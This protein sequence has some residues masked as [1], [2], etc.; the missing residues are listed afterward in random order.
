MT[1]AVGAR[2]RDLR[3]RR[4]LTLEDV[5]A[6]TG[7]S[8]ST[9]SRLE[10][11]QRRPTLELL[12]ALAAAYRVS[13]DDLVGAPE[14]GDRRLRPRPRRV[15]GRA[16]VPLTADPH[17]VQAWK[18]VI[19]ASLREPALRA[20]EGREWLYVLSGRLRLVLG[21][22]DLVLGP[23]EVAAFATTTPHWFG[24][25]GESDV[26]VLSLY[27]RHGDRGHLRPVVEVGGGRRG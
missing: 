3:T 11:D 5:S 6:R 22:E 7:I 21:G 20:H 1:A 17:G 24:S 12:L 27:D 15:K 9:L 4:R 13:L 18:I 26:E 23:A 8:R 14:T 2:V 16:V 19:P 25:T 10:N